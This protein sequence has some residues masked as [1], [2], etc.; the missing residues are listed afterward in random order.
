MLHTPKSQ[1]TVSQLYSLTHSLY[2]IDFYL[3]VDMEYI[4]HFLI[5]VWLTD[6]YRVSLARLTMG[7][8]KSLSFLDH[9]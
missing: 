6:T 7:L 5:I 9:M 3:S 4:M 2:L 1:Y 8:M